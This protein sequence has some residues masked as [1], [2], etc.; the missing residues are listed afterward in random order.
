MFKTPIDYVVE[1]TPALTSQQSFWESIL[2]TTINIASGFVV[3]YI[4]LL[5]LIPVFWPKYNPPVTAAFGMV[6]VFTVTSFL[7]SLIWRRF[8]NAK[9]HIVIHNLVRNIIS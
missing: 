2:E 4:V 8:F 9:L 3:S 1:P 7:R 5:Y 6:V